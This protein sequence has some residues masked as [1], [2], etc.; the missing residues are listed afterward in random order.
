MVPS[1]GKAHFNPLFCSPPSLNAGTH[2]KKKTGEKK[3]K[4]EKSAASP[5]TPR[6]RNSSLRHPSVKLADVMASP[7]SATGVSPV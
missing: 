7:I 3:H 1:N 4:K 5:W 2:Q 6:R